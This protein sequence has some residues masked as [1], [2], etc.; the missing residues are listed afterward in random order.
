MEMA[1]LGFLLMI[2][3][4]SVCWIQ[5]R[6]ELLR[7]RI[8][9]LRRVRQLRRRLLTSATSTATIAFLICARDI[10][11]RANT[12]SR[13]LRSRP[14][15]QSFWYV[16]VQ[17]W[18]D[19]YWKANFR[20]TRDTFGYICAEL[21]DCLQRVNPAG[22]TLSVEERVAITLWRLGTNA[23]YRSISHLFGVGLSTVCVTVHEVCKAIVS[24]LMHQYVSIP[25]EDALRAVR[26]QFFLKWGFPQCV[27]AIDG[28][29]I[30]IIAPK[31]NALDYFNRKGHHSIIMQALVDH[32]Y[33]FMDIY[34]GWP[35]SVHDAR[36]FANSNIYIK[37][38]ANTL[39]PSWTQTIG[40]IEVPLLIL[41]DPAYPLLPWL[42]KP[43]SDTGRL[44][45]KQI[46]FNHRL[47]RA[48]MVVENSFGRLKGRWRSLL[49]RNDTNVVFMPTYVTACCVLHNVCE[50]HRDGFNEEW[51]VDEQ[52]INITDQ[53]SG[54]VQS[55]ST[56]SASTIRD[57]LT[58]YLCS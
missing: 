3:L 6:N 56:V 49:K 4:V 24:K 27:G 29:Y 55:T 15:N 51:L 18:D 36:V 9:Y 8:I 47:S 53:S 2:V 37:G 28:T 33:K 40:G 19:A 13:T 39:F 21:K 57:K 17:G 16:V 50:V 22:R 38:D 32:E 30:P 20:L 5:R 34:V 31:E 35:G 52:N 1:D 58:D 44:S 48:R 14:R 7:S 54:I 41:G 26:D 12:S 23:E 42:M 10:L 25:R 46:D 43:Y 45:R 11:L